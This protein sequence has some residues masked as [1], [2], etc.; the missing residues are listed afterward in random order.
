ME[1][2]NKSLYDVVKLQ[3]EVKGVKLS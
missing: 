1:I 2:T 3:L